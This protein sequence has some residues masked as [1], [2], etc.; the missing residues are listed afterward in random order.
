MQRK[1]NLITQPLVLL[2]MFVLLSHGSKAQTYSQLVELG[3][4][5]MEERD[6]YFAIKMYNQAMQSDSN[7]VEINWKMAEA[8]RLYKDYPKAEYYYDKVYKKENAKI[9]KLSILWLATMQHYNGKYNE[10]L[11]NWKKAK[12]V[13]KKDRDSY[14]YLK[15]AQM[16]KSCLWAKRAVND[17]LDFNVGLLGGDVNTENSEFAG[18]IHGNKLYYSSL[19]ADSINF[20]EE[21]FTTDYSIQIY[22]ADQQ[23]SIFNNVA[24]QKN[25]T[26]KGW[27]TANGSFSP[28]GK[29]FY[30]SR[31]NTNYECKI[32]VGKV[33]GDRI[34]DID[35]LGDVINEPGYISTMPH[36]TKMG[37]YEVLFFASNIKHNFGGLDIWYSVIKDGNQYSLPK[38]LGPDIN[39]MDDEICPYYDTV[40]QVLYFSSSW[41]EGFGGQD[42]FYAKN[43]N[44]TFKN[45]VNVGLPINSTK[46]D[47]YFMIDKRDGKMYFSSNREG[48]QYSKNPNCCSDIFVATK[49]EEP[50]VE[51]RFESL[52]DLNKK[53]PVTLYFHNDE[54]DPKT[55]DT[56]STQDYIESYYKYVDLKTKYKK[57]YAKGLSGDDAESAK[58]DIDDFFVQYVEQGVLDLKE[59]LRLLIIELDKGY[60]IEVTIQGFASPLAKTDYNVPLTKRRINSL[61]KYMEIYDGA[62][63]WDYMNGTA[64]NGGKLTFVKI[65]F[66]EYTADQ[67]ISDNPND[68][69]NSIYARKAALERKIEIQSVSLVTKDSA[70]A[71]MLFAEQAHDFGPV[72]K[73][74][75][76]SWEF[77]FTNNGDEVLEIGEI[78]TTSDYLTFDLSKSV[79]QPGESGK[80]LVSWNTENAQG[81]TYSRV[82][83][84]SNI[85]GGKKELTLTA[86]VK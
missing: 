41:H 31:C 5:K 80:I 36:C 17:T 83:I 14:E 71:K 81:I 6:Y 35:S 68:A 26:K 55:K 13:Y 18:T 78:T 21:V 74:D 86:E 59:F 3:D 8:L 58:E 76:L 37:E 43:Y 51:N 16:I 56:L 63:L 19:K 28:D 7:S 49:P 84:N 38:S 75:N 2:L 64:S 29:R 73:G 34:Y 46:H 12:K 25:V 33:D 70:Y 60:E 62:K 54:P 15:S 10:S 45:P 20:D 42:I 52:A 47:T 22:T 69:K 11:E 85:K 23:D 65:P 24:V 82:T 50:K 72:S 57:E 32:Y 53:L 30:F 27:N 4:K 66:G 61:L 1:L 44:Y 40:E 9:Y 39:T 67:L 48:V 77:S 79:F